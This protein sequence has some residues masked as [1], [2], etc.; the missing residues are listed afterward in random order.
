VTEDGLKNLLQAIAPS[1]DTNL[2]LFWTSGTKTKPI[3]RLFG[4]PT[5]AP[6]TEPPEPSEAEG[7]ELIVKVMEL[8][9]GAA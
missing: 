1:L 8:S 3:R 2:G 4:G 7:S 9:P 5:K 6:L